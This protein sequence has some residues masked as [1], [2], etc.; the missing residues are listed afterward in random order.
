MQTT[1]SNRMLDIVFHRTLALFRI[2]PR[3]GTLVER[4]VEIPNVFKEMYVLFPQVKCYPHG[5]NWRI[6]P[7]IVNLLNKNVPLVKESSLLIQVV[8]IVNVHVIVP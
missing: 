3:L 1:V 7:P 5:M 2:L 4:N 6:S 8:E